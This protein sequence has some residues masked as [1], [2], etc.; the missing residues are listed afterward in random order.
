MLA[1]GSA[2]LASLEQSGDWE[3]WLCPLLSWANQMGT[4]PGPTEAGQGEGPLRKALSQV[5]SQPSPQLPVNT[6]DRI[7]RSQEGWQGAAWEKNGRMWHRGTVLG[8]H[9][10]GYCFGLPEAL[11]SL[12]L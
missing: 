12:E 10:S 6:R 5:C 7:G 9:A 4:R 2:T 3:C 1:G 11:N 8:T